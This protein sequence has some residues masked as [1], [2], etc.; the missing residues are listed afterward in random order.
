[1]LGFTPRHMIAA[2]VTVFAIGFSLLTGNPGWGFLFVGVAG[3]VWG[4]A[5]A[6]IKRLDDEDA[7]LQVKNAEKSTPFNTR[8]SQP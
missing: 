1:M 3:I 5:E 2:G 7:A 6:I 8:R 4:I